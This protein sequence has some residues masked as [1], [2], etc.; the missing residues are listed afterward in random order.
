MNELGFG[1]RFRASRFPVWDFESIRSE[2]PALGQGCPRR[3]AAC[4]L[5]VACVA[6]DC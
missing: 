5:L 1:F 6:F 4:N 2:V 3:Q